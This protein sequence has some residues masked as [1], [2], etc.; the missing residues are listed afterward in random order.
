MSCVNGGGAGV[1]RVEFVWLVCS[2][3]TVGLKCELCKWR[4]AGVVRIE[5]VWLV[6]SSETVGLK[7]ELCKWRGS[8]GC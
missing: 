8:R 6:C 3:E 7:C 1:V 4:G 5:F 2:S